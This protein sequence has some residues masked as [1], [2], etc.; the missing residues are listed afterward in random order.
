MFVLSLVNLLCRLLSFWTVRRLLPLLWDGSIMYTFWYSK[1]SSNAFPWNSFALSIL[2]LKGDLFIIFKVVAEA[3]PKVK[4]NYNI[5]LFFRNII[6]WVDSGLNLLVNLLKF[7]AWNALSI[8]SSRHKAVWSQTSAC[9]LSL[10]FPF[11]IKSN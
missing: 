2:F 11:T 1:L 7:A 9:N 8:I 3:V 6:I 5:T 4:A 10:I